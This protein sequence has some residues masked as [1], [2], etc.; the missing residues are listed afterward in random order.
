MSHWAEL[1]E[2]NIVLRVI[3][4]NN[5]K[6]D[7]GYNWIVKNLGGVWIKTSYNK[8]IRKN[9]A[10]VGYYYDENLDAFIPPKP[11]A[12]WTLDKETC[13]WEP[14]V[15]YPSDGGNYKWNEENLNWELIDNG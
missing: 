2:N 14:P 6:H 1:D 7:E 9:F 13:I 3:V 15:N 10:G 12:S 5:S 11:F 8:N 4:G